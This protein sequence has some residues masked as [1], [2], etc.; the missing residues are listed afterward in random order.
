MNNKCSI[1][2]KRVK[3]L[4]DSGFMETPD[5]FY[6]FACVKKVGYQDFCKKYVYAY[7]E[8]ELK[9]ENKSIS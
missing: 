4:D 2:K 7:K 8:E 9:K 5:G 6:H 1:C 3:F